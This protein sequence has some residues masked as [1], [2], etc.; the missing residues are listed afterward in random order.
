MHIGAV[1]SVSCGASHALALSE[2]TGGLPSV[3][4]SWGSAED[5]LLGRRQQ[6]GVSDEQHTR[7]REMDAPPAKHAALVRSARETMREARTHTSLTG[8]P[9]PP[10]ASTR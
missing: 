7:P 4:V 1:S 2:A 8:P 10:H 3:V 5:G 9:A 6:R